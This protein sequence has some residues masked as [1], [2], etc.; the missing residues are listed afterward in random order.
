[1]RKNS[2]NASCNRAGSTTAGR[3]YRPGPNGPRQP[4]PCSMAPIGI[5][6]AQR[7]RRRGSNSISLMSSSE[8]EQDPWGSCL[9]SAFLPII[10]NSGSSRGGGDD[11]GGGGDDSIGAGSIA[12]RND[13]DD[14]RSEEHTSE[15]QSRP[16]LVCRLLLE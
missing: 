5:F 1:M 15:L 16:Q 3:H 14:D 7:K 6:I 13:G 2:P 10:N 4:T 11:G 8:K 12:A 9:R